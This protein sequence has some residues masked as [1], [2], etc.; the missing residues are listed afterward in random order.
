MSSH[1]N[2]TE[3]E[4][5]SG[6]DP[7]LK[8]WALGNWV[9]IHVTTSLYKIPGIAK[10]LAEWIE[11]IISNL[12]CEICVGHAKDYIKKNPVE[13]AHNPMIWAIDFHN[14]INK[15]LEKHIFTHDDAKKM[16]NE[17]RFDVNGKNWM[18]GVYDVIHLTAF[19]S[20]DKPGFFNTWIRALVEKF[21]CKKFR[22]VTMRYINENPPEKSGDDFAWAFHYHNAM[23]ALAGKPAMEF[24][25][26][27]EMYIHGKI[28]L[29]DKGCGI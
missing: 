22:D 27:Q 3:S 9:G 29:C 21:P 13:K 17:G 25:T 11:M 18:K 24:Q 14:D 19:W 23:N 12:R 15:R 4:S 20:N 5:H 28:K 1:T 8:D 16:I 10:W 2:R 26:V 7:E 6:T